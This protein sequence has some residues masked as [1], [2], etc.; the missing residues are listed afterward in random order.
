MP[1]LLFQQ[2]NF[3]K[4]EIW[5]RCF[6]VNFAKFLSTSFLQNTSGQLL[7]IFIHHGN[8]C[9]INACW[10]LMFPKPSHA[11]DHT[12]LHAIILSISATYTVD[13]Y[14]YFFVPF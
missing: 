9:L 2:S 12:A 13:V 14:I 6:T 3:I 8:G 1:E 7:L 5:H 4:N 10:L 11:G